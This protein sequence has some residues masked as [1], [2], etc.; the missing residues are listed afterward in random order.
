MKTHNDW[1]DRHDNVWLG[2]QVTA[3]VIGAILGAWSFPIIF[4][5]IFPSRVMTIVTPSIPG[6]IAAAIIVAVG[7]TIFLRKITK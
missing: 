7:F 3:F 1:L 4:G 5:S 2:I 6:L